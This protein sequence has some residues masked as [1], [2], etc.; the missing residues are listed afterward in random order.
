VV[1]DTHCWRALDH[2]ER[3]VSGDTYVLAGH[4]SALLADG[5]APASLHAHREFDGLA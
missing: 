1:F 2:V 5:Y 4:S 3:D